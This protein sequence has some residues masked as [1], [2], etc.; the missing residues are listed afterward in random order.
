[1]EVNLC[2]APDG[3]AAQAGAGRVHPQLREG[4]LCVYGGP[5]PPV[6]VRPALRQGPLHRQ[7]LR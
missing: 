6:A 5:V 3:A 7:A 2:I 1:M 4:E